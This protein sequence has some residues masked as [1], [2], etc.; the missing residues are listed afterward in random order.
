[1]RSVR[2]LAW[3][4]IGALTLAMASP[5]VH[6]QRGS[7]GKDARVAERVFAQPRKLCPRIGGRQ[8]HPHALLAIG[9]ALQQ[10]D[11]HPGNAGR[12]HQHDQHVDAGKPPAEAVAL[13][14][15]GFIDDGR[16]CAIP[17]AS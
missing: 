8:L 14:G 11:R 10:P 7:F 6:A 17:A 12:H 1:M 16:P 5:T 13:H 2:N 15:G 4:G 9:Q 3:A